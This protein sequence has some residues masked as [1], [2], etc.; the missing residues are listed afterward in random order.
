[1][2]RCPS[3]CVI[4]SLCLRQQE[5]PH[6]VHSDSSVHKVGNGETNAGPSVVFFWA[7][8]VVCINSPSKRV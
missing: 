8:C 5:Q 4:T 2:I 1:M 3:A 6:F 7:T